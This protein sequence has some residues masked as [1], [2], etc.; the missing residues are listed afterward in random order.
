[1]YLVTVPKI[2]VS[3]TLLECTRERPSLMVHIREERYESDEMGGRVAG[4]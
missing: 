3:G 1:M 2:S 4:T